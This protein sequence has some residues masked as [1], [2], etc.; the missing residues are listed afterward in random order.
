V[1]RISLALSEL[2]VMLDLDD[3]KGPAFKCSFQEDL[4]Q[5]PVQAGARLH[6]V[7]HVIQGR[8][9]D[10]CRLTVFSN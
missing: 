7:P 10:S 4:H 1:N 2:I 5:S 8:R 6:N 3:L 9:H